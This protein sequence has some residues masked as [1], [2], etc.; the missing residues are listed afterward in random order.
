MPPGREERTWGRNILP[1]P[2]PAQGTLPGL[3]RSFLPPKSQRG[4][5]FVS[6]TPLCFSGHHVIVFALESH[7]WKIPP[8]ETAPS[9][10]R[11]HT[12]E[13]ASVPS[14]LVPKILPLELP[15]YGLRLC[16]LLKCKLHTRLPHR[17]IFINS[18]NFF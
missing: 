1:E 8:A 15:S 9:S 2:E 3:E 6:M 13:E 10:S 4:S 14:L 18:T 16:S 17:L 11:H 7:Q 5:T 12:T